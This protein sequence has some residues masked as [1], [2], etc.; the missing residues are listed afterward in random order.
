MQSHNEEVFKKVFCMFKWGVLCERLR[1]GC[2]NWIS[3][4]V[5]FCFTLTETVFTLRH[6]KYQK[7]SSSK[8]I[9]LNAL[10]RYIWDY[11]NINFFA[12]LHVLKM[13]FTLC[14]N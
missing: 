10:T 8:K 1:L 3:G 4:F 12:L 13:S 6:R 2:L 7:K 14:F 5:M 11:V 9:Y